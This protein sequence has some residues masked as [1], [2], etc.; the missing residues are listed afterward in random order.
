MGL[1]LSRPVQLFRLRPVAELQAEWRHEFARKSEAV[2]AT[3][4]GGGR[5]A[6]PGRDLAADGLLLGVALGTRL[7]D[8][9]YG[10]L[11]YSCDLQSAGGATSHSLNLRIAARF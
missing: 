7:T 4:V 6:T 5:F 3:L 9:L 10:G 2:S 8:R 1:S 11:S